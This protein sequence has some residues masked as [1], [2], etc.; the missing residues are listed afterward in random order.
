MNVCDAETCAILCDEFQPFRTGITRDD[1]ALI[2]HALRGMRQFTARGGAEVEHGFAGLRV[3]LG[4]GHRS[5]RVL[6]I[7]ETLLKTGQARQRWVRLQF[8]HQILFQPIPLYGFEVDLFSAPLVGQAGRIRFEC[9]DAGKDGWRCIIP[10]HQTNRIFRAP[11]FCPAIYQPFRVRVTEG[12]TADLKVVEQF[13]R[14]V[15]FAQI[16]AEDRIDETAL[17]GEAGLPRQFNGLIYG[18]VPGN[19]VHP[20][21]LEQAK[22]QKILQIRFLVAAI[23]FARDKPIECFLPTH[24]TI[25]KGLAECVVGRGKPGIGKRF[26]QKRFRVLAA[27]ALA[28]HAGRNFSWFL[29]AH[30]LK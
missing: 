18:S 3:Q 17:G 29:A 27:F 8:E 20:K 12:R 26:F 11:S 24:N 4:D 15:E 22:S 7:K 28:Q 21:D 30:N 5:A 23:G 25:R 2:F 9:I 6:Y 19:A 14:G 1:P 13:S 16:V 10:F